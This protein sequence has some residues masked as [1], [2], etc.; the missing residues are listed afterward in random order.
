MLENS[1]GIFVHS[2][3]F[4]ARAAEHN[5]F[6]FVNRLFFWEETVPVSLFKD[7]YGKEILLKYVKMYPAID[8]KIIYWIIKIIK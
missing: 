2:V 4:H 3:Q 5:V 8:M 6:T 7:A 1:F